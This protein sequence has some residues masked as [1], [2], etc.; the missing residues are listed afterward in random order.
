MGSMTLADIQITP[1]ARIPT[2][3][4]DVMHAMK[5]NDAGFS[6]FG[7]AYFSWVATGA[8]KAW[9]RHLRMTM[10]LV[11]PLGQVRFVF[12]A[13]SPEGAE[14]FRSETI[15]DKRYA[16]IT[17]PPGVWFGFQGVGATPSLVL[18][19]ASLAHDPT[20]VERMAVSD[21]QFNWD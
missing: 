20:E 21:I 8:V 2:P 6:G 17:V 15:G 1:L 18:N 5:H 9:K 11:V 14:E 7:E 3:G 4:G 13:V 12:R 19:M 10:N 16:R